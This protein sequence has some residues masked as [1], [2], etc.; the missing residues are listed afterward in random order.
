MK[1]LATFS[2]V[3]I[4]LLAGSAFAQSLREQAN[5]PQGRCFK[6]NHANVRC[7]KGD[8]VYSPST[9][10]PYGYLNKRWADET[11]LYEWYLVNGNLVVYTCTKRDF[12]YPPQCSTN[13]INTFTYYPQ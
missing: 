12:S 7:L 8:A 3:F 9:G 10:F 6:D 4:S 5:T 11:S 13:N 1:K 2:F